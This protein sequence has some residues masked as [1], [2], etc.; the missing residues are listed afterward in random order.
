LY[1]AGVATA[2]GTR[3]E[4]VVDGYNYGSLSMTCYRVD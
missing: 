2:A 3:P 4:V 1:F